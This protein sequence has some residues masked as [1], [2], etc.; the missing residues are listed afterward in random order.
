MHEKLLELA[1]PIQEFLN[2]NYHQHCAVVVTL[3]NA[4][5]VEVQISTPL[6]NR[7]GDTK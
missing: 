2:E 4:K 7:E 6:E 1:K 5:V 3:D